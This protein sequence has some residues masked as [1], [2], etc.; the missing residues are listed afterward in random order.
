MPLDLFLEKIQSHL[1][2]QPNNLDAKSSSIGQIDKLIQQSKLI[3][4]GV[5]KLLEELDKMRLD[6]TNT[7]LADPVSNIFSY[8]ANNKNPS[9]EELGARI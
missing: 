2:T 6:I 1:Q 3:K 5:N 4:D 7:R 8:L 9:H